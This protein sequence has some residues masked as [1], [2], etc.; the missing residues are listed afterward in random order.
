M[1]LVVLSARLE[2]VP[3]FAPR[4]PVRSPGLNQD[5]CNPLAAPQS[6]VTVTGQV[7]THMSSNVIKMDYQLTMPRVQG[8]TFCQVSV[9]NYSQSTCDLRSLL[10]TLFNLFCVF[11][12]LQPITTKP[13]VTDCSL[14]VVKFNT[15]YSNT[16]NTIAY[17]SEIFSILIL[18]QEEHF[19][20]FECTLCIHV[21]SKQWINGCHG[22]LDCTRTFTK[23]NQ[24]KQIPKYPNRSAS[25]E[26]EHSWPKYSQIQDKKLQPIY[27]QV[28]I[29]TKYYICIR[30][31]GG[32]DSSRNKYNFKSYGRQS[33]WGKQKQ[34]T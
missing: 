12:A 7:N 20:L 16:V 9:S 26:D 19:R 30:K 5:H 6:P 27:M 18:M 29:F 31:S 23:S 24:S 25:E 32:F 11:C 34:K 14:V 13:F 15:Y 21:Q 33:H 28:R 17:Y 22:I 10:S 8:P 4:P 3:P 1:L 2:A